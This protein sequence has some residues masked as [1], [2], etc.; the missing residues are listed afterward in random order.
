MD[1][2]PAPVL[3]NTPV[4]ER[5]RSRGRTLTT[6]PRANK[7]FVVDEWVNYQSG[8]M[9]KQKIRASILNSVF[10][11]ALNWSKTINDVHSNDLQRFLGEVD[12]HYNYEDGTF[13][14]QHPMEFS[15]RANADDN[16]T[17]EEA[18]HGPYKAGYWKAMAKKRNIRRDGVLGGN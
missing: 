14:W 2:V 13:D 16:L 9:G 17:W 18:M 1:E 3:S 12:C 10:L 8:S 15:A 6:N 7:K 11:H 4:P 5:L